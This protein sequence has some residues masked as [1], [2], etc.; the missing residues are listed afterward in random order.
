[1]RANAS[2]GMARVAGGTFRMG[3]DAHYPEERRA[4]SVTVDGFWAD[5][6]AVT[7][8]LL[9]KSLVIAATERKESGDLPR[10]INNTRAWSHAKQSCFGAGQKSFFSILLMPTSPHLWARPATSPL[11]SGRSIRPFIPVRSRNC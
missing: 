8:R 4:Y 11:P 1:M 5:R 2:D 7:N 9:K 3:S 10:R 6:H